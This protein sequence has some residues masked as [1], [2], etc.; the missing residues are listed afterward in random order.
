MYMYTC[1]ESGS[2]CRQV[3]VLAVDWVVGLIR[4]CGL[5]FGG[6]CQGDYYV[7]PFWLVVVCVLLECFDV[8]ARAARVYWILVVFIALCALCTFGAVQDLYSSAQIKDF[9]NQ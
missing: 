6:C 7:S 1:L 3:A 9:S 2:R 5:G 8:V 4:G